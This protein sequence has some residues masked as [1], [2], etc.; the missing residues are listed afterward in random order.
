MSQERVFSPSKFLKFKLF[1][2]I[3]EPQIDFFRR[4]ATKILIK[5]LFG[6]FKKWYRLNRLQEIQWVH[7]FFIEKFI[8][9]AK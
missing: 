8:S 1:K 7:L 4:G 6:V 2:F 3:D 5:S 9:R